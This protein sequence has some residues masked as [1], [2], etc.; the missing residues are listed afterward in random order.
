M[1][2][3]LDIVDADQK[4]RELQGRID[5]T[6]RSLRHAGWRMVVAIYP[7]LVMAPFGLL[8]AAR[9]RAAM[10]RNARK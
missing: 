7:W 6:K 2:A 10:R 5:D 3:A 8:A 9:F 4:L 1:L